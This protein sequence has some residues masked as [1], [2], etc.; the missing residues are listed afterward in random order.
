MT[1]IHGILRQLA[2][3]SFDSM[4]AQNRALRV[5]VLRLW[6]LKIPELN[7]EVVPVAKPGHS[8]LR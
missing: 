4:V 8:S 2:G 1:G 3:F 7:S 6:I 5:S